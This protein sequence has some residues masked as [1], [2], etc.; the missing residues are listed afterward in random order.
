MIRRAEEGNSLLFIQT[1]DKCTRVIY[2]R[3][4]MFFTHTIFKVRAYLVRETLTFNT[5][6]PIYLYNIQ[7]LICPQNPLCQSKS[8]WYWNK[9]LAIFSYTYIAK[10]FGL[11]SLEVLKMLR[12]F[13]NL[14]N[15]EHFNK[16]LKKYDIFHAG[17]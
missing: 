10:V 2:V 13:C 15:F 5:S 8:V 3:W 1:A 11:L 16:L 12:H 9:E 7:I 14:P 6:E 4:K 17:S